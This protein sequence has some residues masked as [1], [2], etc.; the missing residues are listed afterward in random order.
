M[1]NRCKIC[2]EKCPDYSDLCNTCAFIECSIAQDELLEDDEE[3][4]D[5]Y[6]D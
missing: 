2:N 5:E 1:F 6:I 4:E 3:D